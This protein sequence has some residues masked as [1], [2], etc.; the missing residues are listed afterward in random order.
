MFSCS[1]RVQAELTKFG[2]KY[3]DRIYT[4]IVTIW[5]FLSQ[6]LS[7]DGSCEVAVGRV[8]AHRVESGQKPCSENT[9]SYC[10]ARQKL[11]EGFLDRHAEL[12]GKHMIKPRTTGNGKAVTSK[13]SM[14]YAMADLRIKQSILKAGAKR[15]G[16]ISDPAI[17]HALL[18]GRWNRAGLVIGSCRGKKTGELSQFRTLQ[19]TLQSGTILLGDRYYDS[20]Q[21]IANQT[22]RCGRCVRNEESAEP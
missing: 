15:L 11:P 14:V 17:C 2:V 6:V 3:R 22:T 16:W 21:D 19:A 18:T 8:L 9:G 4:P 5:A 13:S 10:V 1:E 12:V 7:K 20:Y